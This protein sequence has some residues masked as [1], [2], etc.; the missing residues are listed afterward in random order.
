MFL[1]PLETLMDLLKQQAGTQTTDLWWDDSQVFD[2]M[3]GELSEISDLKSCSDT[4]VNVED[5]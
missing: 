3:R 1:L 5:L 2:Q 4:K